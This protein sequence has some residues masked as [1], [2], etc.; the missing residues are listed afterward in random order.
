MSGAKAT[1]FLALCRVC[2]Y[3]KMNVIYPAQGGFRVFLSGSLT[4]GTAV[5][6]KA[7][8]RWLTSYCQS[9]NIFIETKER[10]KHDRQNYG[11]HYKPGKM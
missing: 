4:N 3:Q 9:D 8:I 2:R 11:V 6:H 1:A 10:M 5:S 7:G